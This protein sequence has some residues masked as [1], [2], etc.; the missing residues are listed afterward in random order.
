MTTLLGRIP[1]NTFPTLLKIQRSN[2]SAGDFDD[3]GIDSTL[4]LVEDGLGNASPLKLS[5]TQVAI[6]NSTAALLTR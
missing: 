1:A 3:P 2:D 4:R 5:T 6:N